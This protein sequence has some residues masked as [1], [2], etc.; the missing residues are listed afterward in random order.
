MLGID[1][2]GIATIIT[3]VF[4][5]IAAV[6][7]ALNNRKVN[8]V[9]NKIATNGDTREIGQIASDVAKQVAPDPASG[10]PTID[11]LP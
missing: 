3:A 9:Q 5:G 10:A 1:Y 11:K 8:D 6:I 7:S 4:A 2:I